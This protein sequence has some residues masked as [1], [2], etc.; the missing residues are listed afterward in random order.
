MA[1]DDQTD[2]LS[3]SRRATRCAFA[4]GA[5]VGVG[6]ETGLR[7]PNAPE[8]EEVVF[9][10][11]GGLSRGCVG[12]CGGPARF[13][14]FAPLFCS[15]WCALCGKGFSLSSRSSSGACGNGG[16]GCN[17]N[18][19]TRLTNKPSSAQWPTPSTGIPHNWQSSSGLGGSLATC[20]LWR[21]RRWVR[22]NKKLAFCFLFFWC[23]SPHTSVVYVC[24]CV[25]CGNSS[26]VDTKKPTL[27]RE[28]C[29]RAS[30]NSTMPAR[31][32]GRPATEM[33]RPRNGTPSVAQRIA[34]GLVRPPSSTLPCLEFVCLLIKCSKT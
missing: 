29:G 12:A 10:L 14:G 23:R 8:G 34:C 2:S 6:N 17:R 3:V 24:W 7:N 9:R 1:T 31:G 18:R 30:S 32:S 21:A 13:M 19:K 26:A 15:F 5:G 28:A 4:V 22:E 16:C 27:A 11:D 33:A 20:A 25:V